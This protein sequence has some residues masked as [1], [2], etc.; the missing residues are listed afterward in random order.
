MNDSYDV[1]VIGGG[2]AGLNGALMLA[3]SRHSVVV[4]DA[5]APRNAPATGVH[6]L[7]AREGIRPSQLLGRGRAEVRG[8]GGQV[9]TGEVYTV[10]R[11]DAGF[12][13]TL[14]DG[15]TTLAR[16]LLVTAGLTDELPDI[17]GVSARWGRDVLHCP[18]CHG[19]EVRDKAIGVIATGPMS[20]HQAL[21]FRQLSDD[22][23]F[24]AHALP[25]TGEQ[26]E[27]LAAR[28]ITVVDGEVTSLEIA[29][30][31]LTGVRL[32]DGTVVSRDALVVAPHMV[33]RAGFLADLGLKPVEHPSSMGEH[34]PADAAGRT[35]VPGVWVAGNVTDLAA[36]VG[37]AAAASAYAAAQINADLV[38]E[39]TS[40][41]V[42][43][44]RTADH[45]DKA[46]WED[47]Y[48]DHTGT[49]GRE[50]NPHLVAET[51]DL[52]PG[53][54]LDA[55]CGEGAEARWLAE[56]GWQ[57]TA[58][59]ISATA[60]R[61]AREHADS[62][63]EVDWVEADL[64]S[65]TPQE[66]HF[67]LVVSHYVHATTSSAAL[68]HT[69]AAAVAPGG[70]LLIV[71][72]H[73]SDPNTAA[74]GDVHVTAEEIVAGLDPVRWE[75]LVAETRTRSVASTTLHDSVL[76]ARKRP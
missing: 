68:V 75:V 18:Y 37:A 6:G 28:G 22:V 29:D 44:Y 16:R 35:D 20:V 52:A 46:Y 4:I 67:D 36:Q 41:A 30:D 43:A 39:D 3:R 5:G 61:R 57:V 31:R 50:P 71:G 7:L 32:R 64:S 48:R 59:D 47:R 34:I 51:A 73:P 40:Q 2:A 58:V 1:V 56:R 72:H 27:Q 55:G 74:H 9:A 54:A 13:V 33:A 65:W 19:W 14:T 17:P 45:F 38:T 66:G 60:L 23:T 76:K 53:T 10:I 26:A 15:R 11:Q 25:P 8:Y 24:F 70:I 42:A 63:G 12:V 69:L 62:L 21:L 49:C